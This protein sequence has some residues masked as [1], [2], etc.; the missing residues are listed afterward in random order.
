MKKVLIGCGVAVLLG[1]LGLGYLAY[2]VWPNA[3]HMY[4]EWTAAIDELNALDEQYPFDP[5]VQT[6]LD[7][8]RF[9]LM[10]DT[11]VTLADYFATWNAQMEAM[12]KAQDED[13]GPGWIGSI[14]QV[15]DQLAPMLTE[16]A[17]RLKEARMSPQE[18]AFHT[19]VMWAVLARV[20]EGLAGKELESL[21]GRYTKFEQHYEAMRRDQ[22]RLAPLK[23]LLAGLPAEVLKSAEQI[24]ARDLT[25]VSRALAVIDV[26]HLYLQPIERIEDV[27]P[28]QPS[29]GSDSAPPGVPAPR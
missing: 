6:Q 24:M 2:S 19:R 4:E 28:L 15:F 5:K 13:G 20:D 9:E 14:Q 21:R 3:K 23:D 11:R 26:D 29:A 22:K 17:N 27:E 7:A 18:F 10:L 25:Q 8:A 12:K 1:L 16:V